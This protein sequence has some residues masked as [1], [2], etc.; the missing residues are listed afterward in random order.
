MIFSDRQSEFLQ[1]FNFVILCYSQNSLKLDAYEKLGFYSSL[2]NT[3][4]HYG[5]G[6]L[7]HKENHVLN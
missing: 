6:V 4:Y 1:I 7:L 5:A 2:S 3:P